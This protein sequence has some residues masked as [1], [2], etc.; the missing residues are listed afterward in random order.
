MKSFKEFLMEEDGQTNNSQY[1]KDLNDFLKDGNTKVEDIDQKIIIKYLICKS[2]VKPK[3]NFNLKMEESNNILKN[4][5]DECANLLQVTEDTGGLGRKLTAIDG[6][7][8]NKY[9]QQ[10]SSLLLKTNEGIDANTNF[11]DFLENAEEIIKKRLEEAK[12]NPNP[13]PKPEPTKKQ[14]TIKITTEDKDTFV[15]SK[16]P[17]EGGQE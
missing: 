4:F 10:I 5:K 14:L 9:K 16:L 11:K 3:K 15:K 13:N 17:Q 8:Y 12:K 6:Y 2:L 7:I 1:L